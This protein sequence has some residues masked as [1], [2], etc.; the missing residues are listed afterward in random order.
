ME[1]INCSSKNIEKNID[2]ALWLF[3]FNSSL[4]PI[5]S[6]EHKIA[7]RLPEKRAYQFKYSR[8]YIR[9]SLSTLFNIEP[10]QIPIKALPGRPPLLPKKMGYLSLSHS[11]NALLIGWSRYK[12]GV[13]IEQRNRLFPFKAI[14]NKYFSK[15]EK[16][17]LDLLEEN[18]CAEKTLDLWI[19]KEAAIKWQEGKLL[20]DLPNWICSLEKSKAYHLKMKKTI[21]VHSFRFS[22]LLISVASQREIYKNLIICK[23]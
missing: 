8:G 20:R 2:I 22:N 4:K 9:N 19:K 14:A 12:I 16:E 15:Q 1:T 13:D 21:T 10:L 6:K 17:Y 3:D 23:S 11:E 5:S 18:C 7:K